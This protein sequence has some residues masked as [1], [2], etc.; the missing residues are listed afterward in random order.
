MRSCTRACACA[1]AGACSA[2]SSTGMLCICLDESASAHGEA[3]AA[4]YYENTVKMGQR[5]PALAHTTPHATLR[6]VPLACTLL[7]AR[8]RPPAKQ[9]QPRFT[10]GGRRGDRASGPEPRPRPIHL[11]VARSD[12]GDARPGFDAPT[13][14]RESVDGRQ[15]SRTT[16]GHDMG[17]MDLAGRPVPSCPTSPALRGPH[18]GH[19]GGRPVQHGQTAP[20]FH[21][22]DE[23][24]AAQVRGVRC[25]GVVAAAVGKEP[26][27]S[28]WCR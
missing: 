20:G 2:H 26:A 6:V 10:A 11:A 28:G 5:A 27:I 3:V 23:A 4:A 17:A 9:Q 19:P 15:E 7:A 1:R 14:A 21:D 25:A 13:P 22:P 8:R 24:R 16:H 12:L 18:D